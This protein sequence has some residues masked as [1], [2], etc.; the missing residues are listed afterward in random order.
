MYVY[1]PKFDKQMHYCDPYRSYHGDCFYRSVFTCF[2][3]KYNANLTAVILTI[4]IYSSC[5]IEYFVETHLCKLCD[6][7]IARIITGCVSSLRI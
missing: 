2:G 3:T 4:K 1:L 5:E 7:P 6:T